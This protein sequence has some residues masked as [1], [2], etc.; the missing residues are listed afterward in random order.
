MAEIV[1]SEV[2]YNPNDGNY[3]GVCDVCELLE[4][5]RREKRIFFCEVCG[6]WMCDEC[7]TDT[8]RRVRAMWKFHFQR[9]T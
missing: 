1:D 5:D 8:V 6:K 3:Y 7:R 9:R 4:G 2:R